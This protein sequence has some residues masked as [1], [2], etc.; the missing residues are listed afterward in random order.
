MKDVHLGTETGEKDPYLGRE[1]GEKD[2]HLGREAGGW[3]E[4]PCS[5]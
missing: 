3:P 4:A 5:S 1:A 2:L